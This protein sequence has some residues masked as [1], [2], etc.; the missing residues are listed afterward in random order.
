M[1]SVDSRHPT[2][3]DAN[4]GSCVSASL[5]RSRWDKNANGGISIAAAIAFAALGGACI[6]LGVHYN[7]PGF[8][9][10]GGLSIVGAAGFGASSVY[11][12][13]QANHFS[14]Q[15]KEEEDRKRQIIK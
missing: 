11:N 9:V 6:Y 8:Y 5:A 14:K 13:V 1:T 10:I 15:I 2:I 3:S 4:K 12:F 7:F